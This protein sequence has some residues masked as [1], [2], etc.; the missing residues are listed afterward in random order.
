MMISTAESSSVCST[1]QGLIFVSFSL[2]LLSLYRD[3]RS[4]PT[5]QTFRTNST[6]IITPNK[7]K[8]HI[9]NSY[10]SKQNKP[11]IANSYPF[12]ESM[13][14]SVGDHIH[15]TFDLF[16]SPFPTHHHNKT[17]FFLVGWIPLLFSHPTIHSLKVG[18]TP[19]LL[20][21][22]FSH[23]ITLQPLSLS[24]QNQIS[25]TILFLKPQ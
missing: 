16:P 8:T 17:T 3:I 25:Y 5:F 2:S 23:L 14:T 13:P 1:Q 10:Q 4:V 6:S 21:V 18:D 9:T 24:T 12:P 7:R 15:T 20:P 19:L 22:L 11:L